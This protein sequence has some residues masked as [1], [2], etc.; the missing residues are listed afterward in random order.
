MSAAEC[1][2]VF[3]ATLDGASWHRLVYEGGW[4]DKRF[5]AFLGDLWVSMLT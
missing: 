3:S 5:A 2:D 1:R 4:S